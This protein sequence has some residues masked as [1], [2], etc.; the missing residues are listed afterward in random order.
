MTT[1]EMTINTVNP[2]AGQTVLLGL[3]KCQNCGSPMT[4]LD[5]NGERPSRYGCPNAMG[6]HGNACDTPEIETRRMD[7]LVV[8]HL[9]AT[10]LTDDLLQEVIAQVRQE[11]AQ[12]A[13][14]QQ[15]H[16]DT[17]HSE[18]DRLDRDR[19]KLIEEVEPGETAY[20]EV[21]GRLAKIGDGWRAIQGEARRAEHALQCY[22]YVAG[23]EDRVAS[24][25]RNPETYLR[26]MNA[27]ATRSLVE[28]IIDE[29]LMAA[30]SVTVIY[31]MP[32][33]LGSG[34]GDARSVLPVQLHTGSAPNRPAD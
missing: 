10:V 28:L 12:R 34:A 4:I 27:A 24:Y 14:Q 7:E 8:K 11:A 31:K 33:P 9:V 2:Q 5:G 3:A 22:Q 19:T 17:V 6:P 1:E 26:E 16:L 25:A 30:D 32:L 29:V 21:S 23:D 20:A 15:H 13:L 18:T